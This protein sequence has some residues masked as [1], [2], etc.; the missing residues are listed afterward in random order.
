MAIAMLAF[1]AGCATSEY[2]YTT[3]IADGQ[4]L[5]FL[6]RNGSVERA[7]A[8]GIRTIA[9]R[10]LPV[11]GQQQLQFFF[12]FEMSKPGAVRSVKVEDYSADSPILMVNDEKPEIVN[13]RWA[14]ES[15][16]V[17]AASRA[18]DWVTYLDNSFRVYR[19]TVT[20][21]DGHVV[22]VNQGCSIPAFAKAFLRHM[23]GLK[24]P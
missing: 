23:L 10:I 7:E 22:T 4:R 19:Y 5:T 8:G 9:P 24:E 17:D 13:N 2:N 16:P 6:V 11:K 12:A 15:A 3:T 21:T 20:F 1:V 18:L 14:K